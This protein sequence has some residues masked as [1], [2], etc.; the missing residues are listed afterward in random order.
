MYIS[1]YGVYFSYKILEEICI[2]LGEDYNNYKINYNYD[3]N[4]NLS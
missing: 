3:F 1:E 2:I 4:D